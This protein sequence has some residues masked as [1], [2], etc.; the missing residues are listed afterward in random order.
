MRCGHRCASVEQRLQEVQAHQSASLGPL[1]DQTT[2][3][4][5]DYS[6]LQKQMQTVQSE[7]DAFRYVDRHIDGDGTVDS[8]FWSSINADV[9]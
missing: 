1:Q 8:L 9:C 4:Q 2:R 5:A 3:L 6:R 7:A